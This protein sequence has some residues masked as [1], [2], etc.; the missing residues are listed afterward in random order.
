MEIPVQLQQEFESEI[1]LNLQYRVIHGNY[2]RLLA[3]GQIH[4]ETA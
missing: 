1:R 3:I 4:E 2:R